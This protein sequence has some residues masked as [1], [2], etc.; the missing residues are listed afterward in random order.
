MHEN[1]YCLIIGA[2]RSGTSSL[3]TSLRNC[4]GI[5]PS[6]TKELH[7]FDTPNS[8][9]TT[10]EQRTRYAGMFEGSGVRVEASPSYLFLS[11]V[12]ERVKAA[13]PHSRFIVLLRNP[14]DRAFSHYSFTVRRNQELL[15][16]EAALA[17]EPAR[18]SGEQQA[19]LN[20]SYLTRG[21]YSEQ[22]KRWFCHF[23]QDRFFIV[24][25]EDYFLNPKH[26]GTKC[27]SFVLRRDSETFTFVNPVTFPHTVPSYGQVTDKLRQKLQAYF[28]PHNERLYNLLGRDFEW[29]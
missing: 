8:F 11:V 15:S 18:I 14:I 4:S 12:P 9:S 28:Q 29:V 21:I 17:A 1:A 27:L 26:T 23:S 6:Q 5:A 2:M 16:F 24:K 13:I 19:L 25:S 7:I 10:L 22:L 3:F 20:Y